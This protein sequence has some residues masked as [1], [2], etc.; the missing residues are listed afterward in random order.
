MGKLCGE[1]NEISAR[2]HEETGNSEDVGADDSLI[3]K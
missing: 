1:V 3:L 2:K